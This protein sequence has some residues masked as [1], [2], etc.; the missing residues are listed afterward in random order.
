[1]TTITSHAVQFTHFL[2]YIIGHIASGLN[3]KI[4]IL[5]LNKTIKIIKIMAWHVM[6]FYKIIVIGDCHWIQTMIIKLVA[7]VDIQRERI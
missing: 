3:K 6:T 2:L 1:M 7:D 5:E 4:E